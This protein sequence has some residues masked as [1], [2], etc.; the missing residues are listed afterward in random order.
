[1]GGSA[2]AAFFGRLASLS[3]LVL[4]DRRGTGLSDR[5]SGIANLETRMDDVQ[6]V[7]DAASP[8]SSAQSERLRVDG[9]A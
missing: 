6:A 3:R 4:F 9:G 8:A 7:M 2:R 1:M 5:V